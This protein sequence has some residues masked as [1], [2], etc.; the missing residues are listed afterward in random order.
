M[1]NLAGPSTSFCFTASVSQKLKRDRDSGGEKRIRNYHYHYHLKYY[2]SE[3][4]TFL[5]LER[6]KPDN[7]YLAVFIQLEPKELRDEPDALLVNR[8]RKLW[9][10]K[11]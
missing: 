11:F 3:L 7:D 1:E 2:H 5:S 8:F 9:Q 10:A 6:N 4:D